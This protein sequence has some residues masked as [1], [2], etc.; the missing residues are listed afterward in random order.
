[1]IEWLRY[2]QFYAGVSWKTEVCFSP[3]FTDKVISLY[4]ELLPLLRFLNAAVGNAD[5]RK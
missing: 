5:E 2:K 1:M 3:K 4:R